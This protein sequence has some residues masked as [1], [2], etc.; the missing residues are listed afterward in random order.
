[1]QLQEGKTYRDT[2]NGFAFEVDSIEDGIVTYTETA[3]Q[4]THQEPLS[5]MTGFA[6]EPI[7]EI[8]DHWT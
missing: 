2:A 6:H 3:T 4:E 1:M 5:D 8:S 7:V